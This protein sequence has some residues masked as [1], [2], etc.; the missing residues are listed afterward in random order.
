MVSPIIQS[1]L[2]GITNATKRVESSAQNI[3][4]AKSP[5]SATSDGERDIVDLTTAAHDF[6]ANLNTLKISE[7]MHQNLLD[8]LA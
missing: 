7:R 6:K 5:E 1:A 4:A 2:V 8:I 3:A